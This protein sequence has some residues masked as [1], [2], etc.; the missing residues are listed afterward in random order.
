M[1]FFTRFVLSLSLLL[2]F[3]ACQSFQDGPLA[4]ENEGD[5]LFKANTPASAGKQIKVSKAYFEGSHVP[6]IYWDDRDFDLPDFD[7]QAFTITQV[8]INLVTE[9]ESANL[10]ATMFGQTFNATV[11][12]CQLPTSL[13]RRENTRKNILFI[14]ASVSG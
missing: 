2:V 3:A 13:C 12:D 5:D 4:V 6:R 1:R 7:Q 14:I 8:E 11:S 10:C 9:N